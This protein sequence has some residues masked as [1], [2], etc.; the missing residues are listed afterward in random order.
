MN[1]QTGA[2][3]L[4]TAMV[5]S[6]CATKTTS[7]D[8]IERGRELAERSCARC[9]SIGVS[10]TSPNPGAPAFRSLYKLYPVDA[11]G[12]AFA[13]GLKV[14]HRDMPE[15]VFEQQRIRDIL[16]YLRSLNPCG[17]PSSDAVAMAQ[18]FEPL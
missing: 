12:P 17:K 6:A 15:F 18:C 14:G 16:A 10:G 3:L 7:N 9:H 11:L 5:L 13:S 1:M 4:V 8:P 2:L